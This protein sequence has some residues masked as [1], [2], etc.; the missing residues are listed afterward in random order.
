[1]KLIK[2]LKPKQNISSWSKQLIWN[3]RFHKILVEEPD[4]NAIMWIDL[5]KMSFEITFELNLGA[6]VSHLNFGLH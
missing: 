1:M 2:C 6:A 3:N 5:C 4:Q